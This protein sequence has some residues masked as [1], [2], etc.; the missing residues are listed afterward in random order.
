MSIRIPEGAH[1]P[2][3][4]TVSANPKLVTE[5]AHV[6]KDAP[7]A[8]LMH[9]HRTRESHRLT[10]QHRCHIVPDEVHDP[11]MARFS[12]SVILTGTDGGTMA[13]AP[14]TTSSLPYP[15]PPHS[16]TTSKGVVVVTAQCS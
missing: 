4:I 10:G 8:C 14:Y 11:S 2:L 7:L 3:V 16:R 5:V 15:C 13:S 1:T 9:D 12:G 6:L